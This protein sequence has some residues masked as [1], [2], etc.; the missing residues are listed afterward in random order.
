MPTPALMSPDRR[1][2]CSDPALPLQREA[3]ALMA[4]T[5]GSLNDRREEPTLGPDDPVPT[6]WETRSH[7]LHAHSLLTTKELDLPQV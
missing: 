5:L 6:Y 1:K 2:G 4:D 3:Q 7:G